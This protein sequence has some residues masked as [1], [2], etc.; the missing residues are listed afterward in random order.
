MS[1]KTRT[2]YR[3]S[4][5]HVKPKSHDENWEDYHQR[6]N[7]HVNVVCDGALLTGY[8]R[9][10]ITLGRDVIREVAADLKLCESPVAS[11]KGDYAGSEKRSKPAR[12]WFGLRRQKH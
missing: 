2:L 10:Q 5:Q 6:S 11:T 8:G 12:R 9:G 3:V 1:H 4:L 7:K